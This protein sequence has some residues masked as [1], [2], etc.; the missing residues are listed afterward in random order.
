MMK[1]H[2]NNVQNVYPVTMS[3]V[4]SLMDILAMSVN[5]QLH[6]LWLAKLSKCNA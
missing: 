3:G 5:P 4:V 2:Q 1:L 6:H